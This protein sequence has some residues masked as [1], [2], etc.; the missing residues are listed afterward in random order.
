MNKLL[1]KPKQIIV[2]AGP[3][4][5]MEAI[6]LGADV[7]LLG[8]SIFHE[9]NEMGVDYMKRLSLEPV[10]TLT[11]VFI[12]EINGKHVALNQYEIT[13]KGNK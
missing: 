5:G 4:A 10:S 12:A 2:Q 3:Y 13:G 11:K 6:V 1:G 7:D 9:K 8:H